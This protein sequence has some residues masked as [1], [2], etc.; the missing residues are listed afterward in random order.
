LNTWKKT[1]AAPFQAQD[2]KED[3]NQP[4]SNEFG[5]TFKA[6]CGT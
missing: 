1:Q 2:K 5:Q 3:Y 6:Y 4:A